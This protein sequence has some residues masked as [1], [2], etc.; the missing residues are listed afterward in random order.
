M[1]EID[2]RVGNQFEPK[3]VKA[4]ALKTN[5]KPFKL[6]FPSKGSF[7]S[8]KTFLKDLFIIKSFSA[9]LCFF[10][11]SDIQLNA[12]ADFSI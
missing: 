12:L 7:Y 10:A 3:V 9:A 4:N 6:I 2:H 11:I 8:F 1:S 5:Q